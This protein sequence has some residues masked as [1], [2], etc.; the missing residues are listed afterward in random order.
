MLFYERDDI[1]RTSYFARYKGPDG[2]NI[3]MKPVP[4]FKG[5]S[6][7]ALYPKWSFLSQYKKD[8]DKHAY[9][10]AYYEQVLSHL[11]PQEVYNDLKDKTLLCWEKAGLFCHR[12]IIADW[13]KH[14]LGVTVLEVGSDS[15]T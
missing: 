5:P 11:D 2:I 9:T 6:Y 14:E 15:F 1:V 3:A 4:G 8:N 7:P 13:L 12:R 10:K